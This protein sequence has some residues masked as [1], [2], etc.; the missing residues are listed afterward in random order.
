MGHLAVMACT[1]RFF[2]SG[3]TISSIWAVYAVGLL[4]LAL[5]TKVRDLG[6]SSLIIFTASA[7]KVL[8]YDLADSAPAIRIATLVVLGGS[9]YIGGWLYQNL[10][11]ETTPFHDDSEID[12]QIRVIRDLLGQGYDN[13]RIVAWL[14][15]QE[16]PCRKAGGWDEALIATIRRD[17]GLG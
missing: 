7:A 2:D 1:V 15:E 11:S 16:V 5:R 14:I 3:M 13:E 9:L 10:V 8:L 12:E 17:H 4:L 6:Q